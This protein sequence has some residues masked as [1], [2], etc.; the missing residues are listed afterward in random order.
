MIIRLPSGTEKSRQCLLF[1]IHKTQVVIMSRVLGGMQPLRVH[2]FT[3]G[4]NGVQ[5][6]PLLSARKCFRLAGY[7]FEW[8]FMDIDQ[9]KMRGW[10]PADLVGWLND[11][12]IYIIASH[13]HQ[14]LVDTLFWNMHDLAVQLRILYNRVGF[15]S[16]EQLFCPVF[17]QDKFAY[18]EAVPELCNP[19]LKI[20]FRGPEPMPKERRKEFAAFRK[21]AIQSFMDAHNECNGWVVKSPYTTNCDF[22]QFCRSFGCIWKSVIR[23]EVRFKRQ[24][25]YV[26]L[27]PMMINRREDKVVVFNG[28]ASHIADKS[29]NPCGGGHKFAEPDQLFEFA[30]EA[31][32]LLKERVPSFLC[33]GLVRVDIFCDAESKLVVNE[34]ESLEATHYSA[35]HTVECIVS[36][37]LTNYWLSILN[38]CA[39]RILF[40][41][42]SGYSGVRGGSLRLRDYPRGWLMEDEL[43]PSTREERPHYAYF[44]PEHAFSEYELYIV[45]RAVELADEAEEEQ[46][47]N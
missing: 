8:F 13:L 43:P 47:A 27:Q 36:Q 24:M 18:I 35:N 9:V 17:L 28:K 32:K 21:A 29:I 41:K 22:R 42:A 39:Q 12:D 26:M 3:G 31:V 46:A 30:E 4:K 5:H 23:A 44:L 34:F 11:G 2:C 14:G 45:M 20:D 25:S 6:G 33:D 15:P 1:Q 19:T 38:R 10:K 40:E 7:Y 37:V 16:R